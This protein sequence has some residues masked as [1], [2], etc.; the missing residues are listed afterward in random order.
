[1][2]PLGFSMLH[3]PQDWIFGQGLGGIGTPRLYENGLGANFGD[4][5]FVYQYV[6]FGAFIFPYLGYL[7][8][9]LTKSTLQ[10]PKFSS[11]FI[12]FFILL[13]GYGITGNMLEEQ[14]MSIMLGLT[15]GMM[16]VHQTEFRTK[17]S[18]SMT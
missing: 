9:T 16:L 5:F 15:L 11:W 17:K 4:N 7:I 2:W 12:S 1:M 3:A 18:N 14:F 10:Q 8:F 13:F 6:I